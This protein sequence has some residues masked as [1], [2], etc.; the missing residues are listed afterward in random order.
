MEQYIFLIQCADYS[1]ELMGPV[2]RD[3]CYTTWKIH[4][5]GNNY[6][7]QAHENY[8]SIIILLMT[9]GACGTFTLATTAKT[10]SC[11]RSLKIIPAFNNI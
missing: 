8:Y 4:Y 10:R 2:H 1:S 9:T 11:L 7:V 5:T 6:E 3:D